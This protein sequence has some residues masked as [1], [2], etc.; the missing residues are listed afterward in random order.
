[1]AG[2]TGPWM[3]GGG[4][5]PSPSDFG[6]LVMKDQFIAGQ[7]RKIGEY[8]GRLGAWTNSLIGTQ[9]TELGYPGNLDSGLRM[10]VTFSQVVSG[11]SSTGMIGSAQSHGS[12]RGPRGTDFRRAG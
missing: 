3:S 2:L 10:E 6:V 5:V 1:M 9:V 8:L 4:T 11:S 12:S 7:T